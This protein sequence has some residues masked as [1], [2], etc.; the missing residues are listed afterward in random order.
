MSQVEDGLPTICPIVVEERIHYVIAPLGFAG[1]LCDDVVDNFFYW[2]G[3]RIQVYDG[4][5]PENELSEQF[6]SGLMPNHQSA[7]GRPFKVSRT[8]NFLAARSVNFVESPGKRDETLASL[9]QI[10]QQKPVLLGIVRSQAV[11]GAVRA[12]RVVNIS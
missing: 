7:R 10:G 12:Y 1:R 2:G 3:I 5:R 4:I 6:V 11:L 8:D 9:E